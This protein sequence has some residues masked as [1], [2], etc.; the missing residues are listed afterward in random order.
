MAFLDFLFGKKNKHNVTSKTGAT[1]SIRVTESYRQTTTNNSPSIKPNE[2]R[3]FSQNMLQGIDL[4]GPFKLVPLDDNFFNKKDLLMIDLLARTTP[5]LAKWLPGF[6]L[7]TP[8]STHKYLRACILRTEM[9]LGFTYLIKFNA[10]VCGMIFVNTPTYNE[11]TINFPYWSCDFFLFK[12]MQ[13]KGLMPKILLGFLVFL[14]NVFKIQN[15][16]CIVDSKNTAC[17]NMFD[18]C[19]FFKNQPDMIF[20]DPS[21][22]NK[23]IA[24][25]SDLVS[26]EDPFAHLR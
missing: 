22:D 14:K 10:G 26:L 7:S 16:Y 20:T 2:P 21:T 18:K 13:G 19:M 23:A 12:P 17:L 6:D 15:M 1:N 24:F 25:K 8:E 5:E 11:T 4:G 3:T 9:G